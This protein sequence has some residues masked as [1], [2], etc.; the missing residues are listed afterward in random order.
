MIQLRIKNH[1][2]NQSIHERAMVVN[3][4]WLL[5]LQFWKLNWA[6]KQVVCQNL[7]TNN[8]L[9]NHSTHSHPALLSAH[10][11]WS[12]EPLEDPI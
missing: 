12:K 1:D 5:D 6:F 9:K 10:T 3:N 11:K 7:V 4:D 2:E 8:A